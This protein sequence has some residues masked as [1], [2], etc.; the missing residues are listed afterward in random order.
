[1]A[2]IMTQMDLLTKYV[3]GGGYKDMNAVGANSGVSPNDAQFKAMYN[4]EVK[5]FSNQIRGS[6][7]SYPMPRGNHG[8]NRDRG[9]GWRDWDLDW[10]DRGENLRDRDGDKGRYVHPHECPKPKEPK[11]NL[12]NLCIKDMLTCILHK[13]EGSNKV[14][15]K[16]MDDDSSLN[17]RVTSRPRSTR[18][19]GEWIGDFSRSHRSRCELQVQ[20][21]SIQITRRS[22]PDPHSEASLKELNLHQSRWLEFFKDYDINVLYNPGKD[23]V[24]ADALNR[25]F[26][27]SVAHV[28][29]E[30]KELAKHVHRLARLGVGLMDMSDGV[31]IVQNRS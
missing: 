6:R 11:A 24:V 19:L 7:L 22:V 8:W 21:P 16:M 2:K 25:L 4:V 27:G 23:N 14:L 20:V 29:E 17:Q 13:M 12:Q 30:K 3:M 15:K 10:L 28:V 9:D 5:F 18:Q 31:V 26:I 1:M